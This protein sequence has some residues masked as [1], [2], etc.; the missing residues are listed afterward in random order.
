MN[1]T[2]SGMP[3]IAGELFLV[4][5]L[6]VDVGQQR[7]TRAG[8]EITLP[9]LSFQ[10]LLAL[11]RVAPNVLSNDILMA[12]VW[13]GLIVSPETV[14]K[15]VNLLREALGDDA[16]DPHYIAGVRSRGY[17]LVAAV[18]TAR[19]P[20]PTAESSPIVPVGATQSGELSTSD[21]GGIELGT[22]TAK[23]RRNWWLVL[24]VLLAAIVAIAIGVRKADRGPAVGAQPI[25]Q[26]PLREAA[27]IV[28]RRRYMRSCHRGVIS[29]QNHVRFSIPY[30]QDWLLFNA[31]DSSTAARSGW[32]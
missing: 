6:H 23:P 7:V 32:F 20:A 10:M 4:G 1:Q 30:Q 19:R 24:P 2:P 13:P 26:N 15:R 31:E 9:N 28:R 8:I 14:A 17:R 3:D 25:P 5:D 16:Q 12:R 21:K 29:R 18:S 11:I 27:A 22:V